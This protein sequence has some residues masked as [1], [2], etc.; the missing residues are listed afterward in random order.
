[1]DVIGE[2]GTMSLRP[3]RMS[4]LADTF[5][6][7]LRRR[8]HRPHRSLA[9]RNPSVLAHDNLSKNRGRL[10]QQKLSRATFLIPSS[11]FPN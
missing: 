8:R 5:A 1:M 6:S 9:L 11:S 3:V 7:G 4:G 10:L 2:N